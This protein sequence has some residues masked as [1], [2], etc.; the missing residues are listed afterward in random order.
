MSEAP[1]LVPGEQDLMTH[2]E[3]MRE[4]LL[5]S[6]G[7]ANHKK[8]EADTKEAGKGGGSFAGVGVRQT[9]KEATLLKSHRVAS[10]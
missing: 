6:V 10:Q 4:K 9:P 7:K 8:G 2:D 5:A 3:L 1:C